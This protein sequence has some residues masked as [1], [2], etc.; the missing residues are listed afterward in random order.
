M[1]LPAASRWQCRRCGSAERRPGGKGCAECNRRTA[2][3]QAARLRQA[4]GV[5]R[6]IKIT[7][8]MRAYL[9]AF[10]RYLAAG[11]SGDTAA[12]TAAEAERHDALVV[13]TRGCGKVRVN[14]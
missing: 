14:S 1:A 12:A 7:P 8:A 9:A 5:E 13:M 11:K 3:E 2:R 6:D 4:R 10:D